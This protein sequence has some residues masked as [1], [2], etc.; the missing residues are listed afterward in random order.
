MVRSRLTSIVPSTGKNKSYCTPEA[1]KGESSTLFHNKG[2]GTFENVTRKAGL[3]DP[4]SKAL[5]IALLDY[6]NDGWLDLFVANDTEPNKLYR[7]N[8]DGTFT[9]VGSAGRRG[10]W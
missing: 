2:N 9:D 6:D 4:T 3:H 7:N 8:H 5:G 1:F 10:V